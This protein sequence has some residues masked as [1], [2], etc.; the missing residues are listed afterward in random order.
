MVGQTQT[1]SIL[2]RRSVRRLSPNTE[3]VWVLAASWS[4]GR[5]RWQWTGRWIGACYIVWG[6][7]HIKCQSN[8]SPAHRN[9]PVCGISSPGDKFSR[10]AGKSNQFPVQLVWSNENRL[11][12]ARVELLV[13]VRQSGL[14]FSNEKITQRPQAH[15][16]SE[17][18]K[19]K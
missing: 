12:R 17:T 7:R 2:T 15:S 6:Y 14:Q 1:S 10:I 11:T 18:R 8:Q 5:Y 4:W 19:L 3:N 16:I 13:H 9:V